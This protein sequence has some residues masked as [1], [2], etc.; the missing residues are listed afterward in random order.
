MKEVALARYPSG[1]KNIEGTLPTPLGKLILKWNY[2]ADGRGELE[3]VIPGAMQVKL[4]L[5]SLGLSAGKI[6][7]VDGHP[8]DMSLLDSKILTLTNGSHIVKF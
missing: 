4:D 7:L 1:L 8:H 5:Q 2:Y 3:V 6:I